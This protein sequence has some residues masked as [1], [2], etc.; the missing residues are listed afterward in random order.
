MKL[1][2]I[3]RV[4]LIGG[5]ITTLG[6]FTSSTYS[7]IKPNSDKGKTIKKLL[8]NNIFNEQIAQYKDGTKTNILMAEALGIIDTSEVATNNTTEASTNNQELS[9]GGSGLNTSKPAVKVQKK[10]VNNTK[11]SNVTTSSTSSNG[12]IDEV[13]LFSRLVSAEATGESFDGQLAVATVIMNRVNSPDFPK[14]ITGVIYDKTWGYQFTPILDGRINL[15]AS[16][17]AKKAVAMVLGG[18]R[19]FG[20][21]VTYFLNPK[22]AIST[23]IINHKTYFETIGNHDFYH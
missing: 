14:T 13:D 15:P 9:R 8:I 7:L 18:Y 6:V 22:K 17:S 20:A 19:S 4:I 23:W 1:G 5:L 16:E 11:G 2:K 10:L 21:D 12:K 3:T